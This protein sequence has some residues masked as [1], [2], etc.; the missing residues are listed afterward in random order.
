MFPFSGMEL[1]FLGEIYI[2][3][4][5]LNRSPFVKTEPCAELPARGSPLS[6]RGVEDDALLVRSYQ[7][8]NLDDDKDFKFSAP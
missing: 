3:D 5:I 6:A 7:E 8:D 1:C 2:M 4:V